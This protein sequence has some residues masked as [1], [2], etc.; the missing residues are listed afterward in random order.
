MLTVYW[1]LSGILEMGC[2]KV[3]CNFR[4]CGAHWL[5]ALLSVTCIKIRVGQPTTGGLVKTYKLLRPV[6]QQF[7]LPQN[8]TWRTS[9]LHDLKSMTPQGGDRALINVF[10][11]SGGL[12]VPVA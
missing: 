4:F 9:F 7:S 12:S 10:Q 3:G 6:N 1:L 11:T 2:F 5:M 8:K